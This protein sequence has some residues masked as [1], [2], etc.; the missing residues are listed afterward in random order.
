MTYSEYI[1]SLYD[2]LAKA[3]GPKAYTIPEV[4]LG[5]LISKNQV[6]PSAVNTLA[7]T[8]QMVADEAQYEELLMNY[9]KLLKTQ[10]D[11][12]DFGIKEADVYTEVIPLLNNGGTH[13]LNRGSNVG[14]GNK[15]LRLLNF[16]E[17]E[18]GLRIIKEG[19]LDGYIE[20]FNTIP[21]QASEINQSKGLVRRRLLA[22][23]GEQLPENLL[24][25]MID[26]ANSLYR[27]S[28]VT[29]MDD[30]SS[31]NELLKS[32]EKYDVLQYIDN[33]FLDD[34]TDIVTSGN[35]GDAINFWYEGSFNEV[36]AG[37]EGIANIDQSIISSISEPI[38]HLSRVLVSESV[39][40]RNSNQ[41][42]SLL[43][44]D[45]FTNI[46]DMNGAASPETTFIAYL[47]DQGVKQ[48]STKEFVE[49]IVKRLRVGAEMYTTG[50]YEK[51]LENPKWVNEL[52]NDLKTIW[53]VFEKYYD[54]VNNGMMQT[55]P[56]SSGFSPAGDVLYNSKYKTIFQSEY[57]GASYNPG[58]FDG[59]ANYF[60]D[61]PSKGSAYNATYA[62]K[63]LG[64]FNNDITDFMDS[65]NKLP[66]GSDNFVNFIDEATANAVPEIQNAAKILKN[67]NLPADNAFDV[68][69]FKPPANEVFHLGPS[70]RLLEALEDITDLNNIELW[71]WD[72]GSFKQLSGNVTDDAWLIANQIIGDT[73]QWE[74]ME[75]GKIPDNVV[76]NDRVVIKLKKPKNEISEK[77]FNIN[78]NVAVPTEV[79]IGERVDDI[80]KNMDPEKVKEVI[81][82]IKKPG[83][84]KGIATAAINFAKKAGKFTG[85]TAMTALAP[86]DI[87]IE[88]GIKRLL[89]RL[90]VAAISAPALAAYTTYELA[91]AAID[92]G[93]G[94]ALA[95]ER[96]GVGQA[97]GGYSF[98]GGK[99]IEGKDVGPYKKAD[100]S[101]YG[102]DFWEGFTEDSISDKYSIGYKL[103]KEIHNQLF[104]DVYDTINQ[105]LNTGNNS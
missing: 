47:K 54:V 4:L 5:Q 10:V 95:N 6:H 2:T 74:I 27:A 51:F 85:G 11:N 64:L 7:Q 50:N 14:I 8:I 98:T 52:N 65:F 34:L 73:K 15:F 3:I 76:I 77:I 40:F 18:Y 16:L 12:L 91:L 53:S 67:K 20:K 45:E 56:P 9:F 93:K 13:N 86:G 22:E 68:F 26:M 44:D 82:F 32:I 31:L 97:Y 101:S 35:K 89:P 46:I 28:M 55:D 33:K 105:D 61:V 1:K 42:L 72:E 24:M 57:E 92:V 90:G 75:G 17:G 78:K 88:Q 71:D 21:Q 81:D 62:T 80:V 29:G 41:I 66:Q 23:I 79:N 25:F 100:F 63:R 70:I 49:D 99:T 30:L 69:S 59:I 19:T 43:L 87:A 37:S 58:P 39:T 36:L 103:T 83:I 104:N 84:G 60:N 48:N 102:K 94:L 96:A 38:V